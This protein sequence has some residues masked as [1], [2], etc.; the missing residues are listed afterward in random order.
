MEKEFNKKV[1]LKNDLFKKDYSF[2]VLPDTQNIRERKEEYYLKMMQW[3]R[4]NQDVYNIKAVLHMGDI[5]N[6]NTLREWK[7]AKQGFDYLKDIPFIPMMGNHDNFD[8]FNKYVSYDEYKEKEYFGG[9][10]QEGNLKHF[11]WFVN[12]NEV[13]YLIIS[14]GWAPSFDVLNWASIVIN[15]FPNKRVIIIS[16]VQHALHPPGPYQ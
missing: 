4:D 11:Y 14:L 12:C 7:V 10:Y 9:T 5:V 8:M 15:T 3:I 13:G 6:S 1:F 2:V 16:H